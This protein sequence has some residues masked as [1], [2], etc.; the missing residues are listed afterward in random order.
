MC[1]FVQRKLLHTSKDSY[2]YTLERHFLKITETIIDIHDGTLTMKLD[3][4]TTN[5]NIFKALKY[6]TN[7]FSNFLLILLI[8][9]CRVYLN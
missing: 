8:F 6:L 3:D 4:K 5:F 1:L 2:F 7:D 9:Q